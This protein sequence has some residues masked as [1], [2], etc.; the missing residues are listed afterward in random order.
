[1]TAGFLLP[2]KFG[3]L[4]GMIVGTAIGIKSVVEG[5]RFRPHMCDNL[6]MGIGVLVVT[7]SV[8]IVLFLM[9][10]EVF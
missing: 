2:A 3:I 10:F 6:F 7:W 9:V 5:M 4:I 8:G 1:M